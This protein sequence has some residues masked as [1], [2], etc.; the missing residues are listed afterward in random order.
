MLM[1]YSTKVYCI[2]ISSSL[3]R[4]TTSPAP[5]S[6]QVKGVFLF[7]LAIKDP[8]NNN[9]LSRLIYNKKLLTDKW[10]LFVYDNLVDTNGYL[11]LYSCSYDVITSSDVVW[12]SAALFTWESRIPSK[13]T[14][15][16]FFAII[17]PVTPLGAWNQIHICY[18]ASDSLSIDACLKSCSKWSHSLSQIPRGLICP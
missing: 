18:K 7:I 14:F 3:S 5:Y 4:T 12:Q 9:S 8:A 17:F 13:E 16:G 2:Y 6:S 15:W 11:Y 1:N 10:L